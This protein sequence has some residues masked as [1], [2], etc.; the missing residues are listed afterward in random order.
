MQLFVNILISSILQF[1]VVNIIPFVWWLFSAKKKSIKYFEWLGL[2]TIT[3]DSFAAAKSIIIGSFC[4]CI[5]SIAI[6]F[7]L[8]D[9][10]TAVSQFDGLGAVG[11]VPAMLYAFVQTSLTEEIFFRGFLLKRLN[12]KFHFTTANL[13]QSILFGIMHGVMFFPLTTILNT[14]L[15]ILFTAVIA[16]YM[17]YINETEADGSIIPSWCI[18]GVANM[19]SAVISLFSLIK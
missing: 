1:I 11:L 17:G 8:R 5:L 3:K 10:E 18:H 6:L 14:I 9:I 13:I 15:I 2:K 4:F 12:A 19:F 7:I 16:F